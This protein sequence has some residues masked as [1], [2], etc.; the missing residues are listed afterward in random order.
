MAITTPM[1][2]AFEGLSPASVKMGRLG[3]EVV[4]AMC[5]TLLLEK[6]KHIKS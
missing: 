2:A 4:D 6:W 5:A 3:E 1:A